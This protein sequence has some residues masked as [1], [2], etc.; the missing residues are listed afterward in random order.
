M[1][2][3]PWMRWALGVGVLS[4]LTGLGWCNQEWLSDSGIDFWNLPRLNRQLQKNDE[5]M[6]EAQVEITLIQQRYMTKDVIVDNLIKERITLSEALAQFQQLNACS[7]RM[8]EMVGETGAP[9][10][11]AEFAYKNL[12]FFVGAHC[13]DRAAYTAVKERLDA[14]WAQMNRQKEVATLNERMGM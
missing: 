3:K 2:L 9:L 14:D 10:S 8:P 5:S 12:L 11:A 13:K 7:A 1:P 6:Q 4:L